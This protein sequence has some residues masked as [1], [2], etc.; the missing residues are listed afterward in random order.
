MAEVI[1]ECPICG[2]RIEEGATECPECGERFLDEDNKEEVVER[3]IKI[4]GLGRQR[5]IKLY[6]EGFRTP[7]DILEA[8]IE[9]VLSIDQIGM[10]TASKIIEK[11]EKL[12][13]EEEL[14]EEIEEEEI[15]E[16]GNKERTEEV[17]VESITE[18]LHTLVEEEEELE[19]KPK[20]IIIG[21]DIRENL[22]DLIPVLSAFL[23]PFFLLI[24]VAS[25]FAV[26]MLD[27]T[28][29]YPA[30]P[31]Y[32]LTPLP[33]VVS[34]W[35]ASII[36]SFLVVVAL[37]YTTWRGYDFKSVF[38]LRV[39]KN[40][41]FISALLSVIISVSLIIHVYYSQMYSGII[42]TFVL[43]I[44][45]L[46]M[47]ITQLELL[48]KEYISFPRIEEKK[49]CIECGGVMELDVENCL[50]CGLRLAVLEKKMSKVDREGIWYST[51]SFVQNKFRKEPEV[52]KDEAG[53]ILEEELEE[54]VLE[55]EEEAEEEVPEWEEEPEKEVEDDKGFS[56]IANSIRNGLSS[57]VSFFKDK[58]GGESRA[59]KTE[60]VPAEEVGEVE[61]KGICPSCG[62][63]IPSASEE[64]PECGEE[65]EPG[66]EEVEIE[67]E[68]A[69][70][71]LEKALE[72]V[73]EE[74]K[75]VTF[76]CPIC[77]SELEETVDEC[78]ECGTVFVENEEG[79]V[80]ESLEEKEEE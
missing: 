61:E 6:D 5:A 21:D 72:E 69:L 37:F 31:L 28:S 38:R 54:E 23:I 57:T 53:E 11:T 29:I 14:E 45:S 75:T 12:V 2:A 40:M 3:L 10:R 39:D 51:I 41:I 63:L 49:V 22:W 16:E 59:G 76:I 67:T 47:L 8:G 15:V 46:F 20:R 42:L 60:E 65:L 18:D 13:E 4:S 74:T 56:V 7:E 71:D 58:L 24:L 34:S 30:Q 70:H 50:L 73:E 55:W 48:R 1:S 27:Y 79:I 19:E 64:C 66:E 44:L 36:L 43:L 62:A 9:G 80:E 77:D 78:P 68:S 17:V 26:A 52:P 25:E 33:Y 32:Y 35:I